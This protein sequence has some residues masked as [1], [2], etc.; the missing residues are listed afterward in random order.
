VAELAVSRFG[1]AIRPEVAE[2]WTLARLTPPSALY[3]ANGIRAGR[4]GRIY[5]AQATGSQISAIDI[6]TLSIEAISPMGGAIVGPDD[7]AFGP[8]DE[9]FVT[10]LMEARVSVLE[11][12]GRSHTLRGD[13]PA[14][15]GITFHQGRLFVD[16]SR[17]H[18][19]M[20]E[21]S[22]DG[23]EPGILVENIPMANACEVGPDGLLYFPVMGANEIWRVDPNGGPPERV[24]GRLGTPDSVKF[25][26]RGY[27]VST[28][29][30]SGEVL[31]IDPRDG[32]RTVLAS[33]DPGLDNVTFIGERTFV[34]HIRGELY[35]ILVDGH[36]RP[37]LKGGMVGPLGLT[38]A[39]DGAVYVADGLQL[40]ALHP[41]S[42]EKIVARLNESGW[43]GSLRGI[44]AEGGGSFAVT[45]SSG[46]A[47]RYRPFEQESVLLADG[48][49]QPHGVAVAPGGTVLVAELGTGRVLSVDHAGVQELASGLDEPRDVAISP[50]G[51]CYV[52]ESGAGRIIKIVGGRV[53][54]VV[55]G[56][57]EPQGLAW[58]DGKLYFIDVG[59]KSLIELSLESGEQRTLACGL[60]VGSPPGVTP[61]PLKG[62]PPLSGPIRPL[63]GVAVGRNG[64]IYISADGEGSVLALRPAK[65][66][67]K[68]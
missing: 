64:D 6:D 50:E 60:P 36:V 63:A 57:R 59:A 7:L 37:I 35:E 65:K 54:V 43:P 66:I 52:S 19:R 22:L 55:D 9:I 48:L 61:K 47:A 58:R 68:G 31:R 10:E 53:E 41:G 32:N 42:G 1:S 24:V 49:D 67:M 28:Q 12:G 25:D 4:D 29:L 20:I 17:H 16:E 5:I 34:S 44:A 23:G 14:A 38:V 26:S 21:I 3:G 18:G 51:E 62:L 56:L 13:L 8:N 30:D 11:R 46:A 45:T 40:F 15:N 33:L 27:I 39:E 2:G